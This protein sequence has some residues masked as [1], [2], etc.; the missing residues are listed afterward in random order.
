LDLTKNIHF[1]YF[2]VLKQLFFLL[3]HASIKKKRIKKM[4]DVL[5][6]Q[7]PIDTDAECPVIPVHDYGLSSDLIKKEK[8]ALFMKNAY[9]RIKHIGVTRKESQSI[10]TNT[11]GYIE[12]ERVEK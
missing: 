9:E 10:I 5:Q 12:L 8:H 11:G 7:Q 3:V 1:F 2:C 4:I 6:T